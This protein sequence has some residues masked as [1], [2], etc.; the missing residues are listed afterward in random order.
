ME[1]INHLV[2]FE[3]LTPLFVSDYWKKALFET[4]NILLKNHR[5]TCPFHNQRSI[6]ILPQKK[7]QKKKTRN[8]TLVYIQAARRFFG[9]YGMHRG[10]LRGCSR[11]VVP[12]TVLR[13][14]R[15]GW[16][17]LRAREPRCDGG[18]VG[19]MKWGWVR[20]LLLAGMLVLVR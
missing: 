11:W 7:K 4:R 14:G 16:R 12:G 1:N 20:L 10:I 6:H 15:E 19:G 17:R 9:R 3:R 2:V 5:K 13:N 8:L 18:W